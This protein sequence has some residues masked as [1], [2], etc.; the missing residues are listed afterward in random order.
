MAMLNPSPTLGRRQ[1]LALAA[2][3]LAGAT[4]PLR[5]Q[6]AA[7]PEP[8][9]VVDDTWADAARQRAVPV[10][11]RWPAGM[12]PAGGWPVVLFSHGLG[13]TRAGGEVWGTAWAAAGFVVVHLQHP[14]SDLDAVRSGAGS[15]GNR[16]GLRTL[17]GPQ[18]LLARLQDVGFMLDELARRQAAGQARWAGVRATRVGLSGHSFGAHTTLGMAGQRYPGH[19]GIDE[20]RLA[21]FVAFSPTLPAIGNPQQ[22]LGRITRP[23]LSI[24]GTRDD[25]VVG[26]GA[27]PE[28]RMAVY[29]ALPAGHKAHL[30]LQDA[31]HMTFGGQTGRAAEIVPRADITR[32]LQAAHHARV[33]AI[34]T[35]WW[36]ATLLDDAA[37]RARLAAPAGLGAG[38][39]WQTG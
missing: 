29:A 33:A 16:Q 18:Q 20:P 23:V 15:F 10:R 37:A 2:S 21:A 11:V 27:T 38:D 13:G 35:D 12:A 26:V 17:A 32:S 5:A 39:V 6:P 30:V 8:A 25:D 14:G 31:D 1:C 36:R 28:R 22:V 3:A 34:T 24:T 19:P 7:P 9:T 4:L